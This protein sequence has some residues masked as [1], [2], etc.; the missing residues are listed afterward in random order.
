MYVAS[1]ELGHVRRFFVEHKVRAVRAQQLRRRPRTA[2]APT[3][4]QPLDQQRVAARMLR[5]ALRGERARGGPGEIAAPQQRAGQPPRVVLPS[6]FVRVD[7]GGRERALSSAE[8][9]W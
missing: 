1:A 6:V 2:S 3:L 5:E 4:G 8:Q 7:S 9:T